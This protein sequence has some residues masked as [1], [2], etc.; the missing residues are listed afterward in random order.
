MKRAVI[1]IFGSMLLAFTACTS[2]IMSDSSYRHAVEEDFLSR[3]ELLD[4]ACGEID[5]ISLT[6][7]EREGM[8][9]V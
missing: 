9:F 8:E 1:S 4:R 3:A 7:I 6:R 5:T 2:G